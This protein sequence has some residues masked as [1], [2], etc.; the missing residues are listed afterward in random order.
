[1]IRATYTARDYEPGKVWTRYVRI[2]QD[3]LLQFCEVGQDR[4]YDLRQGTCDRE[5]V[6]EDVYRQALARSGFFPSY[7][8]WPMESGQ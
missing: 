8:T 6:S 5:D 3:G 2:D 1:M 7:V 4:R